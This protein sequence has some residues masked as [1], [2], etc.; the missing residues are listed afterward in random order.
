MRRIVID[1][2]TLRATT[3]RY[4]ERLLHY[5]QQIDH[6]HEY[7]VL[8]RPEDIADWNPVAANFS[9]HACRYTDFSF[10]EQLGFRRQLNALRA[11]LV[12]FAMTQQP[13]A[14]RGRVVTTMHDL[15]TM[16]FPNPAKN[17]VVFASKQRVYRYVVKRVARRSDAVITP[18]RFVAEDV[19]RYTGVPPSRF[20]VTYEAADQIAAAA[21][22]LR[23]VADRRFLLY[24]GRPTPHKNLERLIEAFSLLHDQH[25]DLVLVLAGRKDANYERIE[26]GALAAG[27]ENLVFTGFVAE[28]QLRWLYERCEAYVFP[29]LSEGFGLPG[30][31]A[32]RHGAPVLASA[33]TCLPEIYG[34][35]ARYFD[36]LDVRGMAEAIGEVVRSE[37]LQA[38]LVRR[39]HEQVEKYSWART[40]EQTL[41]VYKKVLEAR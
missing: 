8:L 33:A 31:E 6:R 15:T 10:G 29:S 11:D 22:P 23:G 32:M 3:G 26:C 16:R 14:Y 41:E 34:D 28:G 35:A 1:A 17:R 37:D 5:L 27:V 39:G 25:P 13:I 19:A 38:D 4:V 36:Q 24:V 9:K 7:V 21:E 12:H 20:T 2:R 18:S 30:L 40:A